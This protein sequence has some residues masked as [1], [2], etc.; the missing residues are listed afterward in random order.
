M[1]RA[2]GVRVPS[3]LSQEYFSAVGDGISSGD[4]PTTTGGSSGS[5]AHLEGAWV[6]VENEAR[7]K[8]TE[9]RMD[10]SKELQQLFYAIH[11]REREVFRIAKER[12]GETTTQELLTAFQEELSTLSQTLDKEEEK[13]QH[14]KLEEVKLNK[15]QYMGLKS[16]IYISRIFER[17]GEDLDDLWSRLV[18]ISSLSKTMS[19]EEFDDL[20]RPALARRNWIEVL[21]DYAFIERSHLLVENEIEVR[22]ITMVLE[23]LS[24]M[25]A[26]F[27]G[28]EAL[29]FAQTR[30]AL[31]E[32]EENAEQLR[33]DIFLGPRD[34]DGVSSVDDL[35]RRSSARKLY[36]SLSSVPY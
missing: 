10:L 21:D 18:D 33:Q 4:G 2:L 29:D 3:E 15:S 36:E 26:H 12:P 23:E 30:S 24:G 1:L 16:A 13:A 17:Y 19:R 5:G 20:R 35:M 25:L 11:A 7:L 14:L 27:R 9:K 31:N 6:D 22:S 34:K 8:L 28:V 32:I